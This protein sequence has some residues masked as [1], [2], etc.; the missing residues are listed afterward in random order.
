MDIRKHESVSV[1]SV[2]HGDVNGCR[3]HRPGADEGMKLAVLA[4]GVHTS[5]KS[6]KEPAIEGASSEAAGKCLGVDTREVRAQA[7]GDHVARELGG[8]RALPQGEERRESGA[9]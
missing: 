2:T 5:R 4:A 6:R 7:A 9:G 1:N 8:G 3:E